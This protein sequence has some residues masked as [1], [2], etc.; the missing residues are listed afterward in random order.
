VGTLD[1]EG[2]VFKKMNR[3]QLR[4]A[5][6]RAKVAGGGGDWLREGEARTHRWGLLAGQ[7]R[8][9]ALGRGSKAGVMLGRLGV[10]GF[11]FSFFYFFLFSLFEYCFRF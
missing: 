9:Y 5:G 7:A 8:A 4:Q 10:L 11:I 1:L 3:R 2:A 6:M